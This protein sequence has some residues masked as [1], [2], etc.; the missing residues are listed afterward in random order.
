MK[1]E[2]DMSYTVKSLIQNKEKF[3]AVDVSINWNFN[4]ISES[5]NSSIEKEGMFNISSL[6]NP[7]PIFI[8]NAKT[9]INSYFLPFTQLIFMDSGDN[10]KFLLN[11]GR[12]TSFE[13]NE[14]VIEVSF[15]FHEANPQYGF[16]EDLPII[17][18]VANI[19]GE[20]SI[21]S[22]LEKLL[23]KNLFIDDEYLIPRCKECEGLKCIKGTKESIEDLVDS[24]FICSDCYTA[25]KKYCNTLIDE[26]EKPLNFDNLNQQR[27][28]L[29]K[30]ISKGKKN[31]ESIMES[32]LFRF[33][34]VFYVFIEYLVGNFQKQETLIRLN[35][36]SEICKKMGYKNLEDYTGVILEKV[37]TYKL[38]EQLSTNPQEN[39]KIEDQ[40]N[41]L[42]NGKNEVAIVHEN[43]DYS[44]L[45]EQTLHD[46]E[47]TLNKLDTLEPDLK[48]RTITPLDRLKFINA[49]I[50]REPEEEKIEENLTTS[51]FN[52]LDDIDN[53]DL[54]PIM[55]KDI[56]Q[57]KPENEEI[58]DDFDNVL[59]KNEMKLEESLG[60]DL[61][62]Y[63]MEKIQALD[64]FSGS[65]E[66]P[67]AITEILE[68]KKAKELAEQSVKSII[69]NKKKLDSPRGFKPP[70][71]KTSPPD[72]NPP[73]TKTLPPDFKPPG[74]K[75]SPPDFNPPGTTTTPPGFNSPKKNS[76]PRN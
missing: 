58:L 4:L 17:S 10:S 57:R 35:K 51:Y 73:G 54:K 3:N 18:G 23:R 29:M 9:S 33:Y 26:F 27:P 25:A 72:F 55:G 32:E 69:E 42:N 60:D 8:P 74:A 75:T 70:G 44:K 16:E 65:K 15:K 64:E 11:L 68:N 67:E 46:L 2:V 43:T 40:N 53:L 31:A 13:K 62:E 59:P 1:I 63:V 6:H 66:I 22:N 34:D 7:E 38:P 19:S 76:E 41:S 48:P 61:P 14:Q 52:D 39:T 45:I 56:I 50:I 37:N 12:V 49:L 47:E 28:M 36:L 20:E 21:I 71:A 24:D 5:E 30:I